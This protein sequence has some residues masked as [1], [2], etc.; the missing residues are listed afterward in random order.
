MF[1]NTLGPSDETSNS[2]NA[3]GKGTKLTGKLEANGPLRIDGQIIG[4]VITKSK[5]VLGDSSVVEGNIVAQS[6]DIGGKVDGKV[7]VDDIL[8][9][10]PSCQIHGDIVTNRLVVESGAKLSGQCDIGITR[11][12]IATMGSENKTVNKSNNFEKIAEQEITKAAAGV[13]AKVDK[14]KSRMGV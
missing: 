4:D 14:L 12:P 13:T 8:T 7:E 3:I 6:A 2:T 11:K 10:K 9:L 5:I 1:N